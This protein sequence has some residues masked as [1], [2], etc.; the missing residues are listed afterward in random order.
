MYSPTPLSFK[1]LQTGFYFR[2]TSCARRSSVLCLHHTGRGGACPSRFLC[3]CNSTQRP[4][5]LCSL[6]FYF[7]KFLSFREDNIFPYIKGIFSIVGEDIILPF[8]CKCYFSQENDGR[9]VKKREEQA[10]PLPCKR[11][12][13]AL[14]YY[15]AKFYSFRREQAP[16]LQYKLLF[17]ALE[18][19]FRMTRTK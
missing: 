16:A 19:Y 6:K 7:A 10:P 11:L 14:E 9:I 8:L 3:K 12:F 1:K 18:F 2:L 4:C 5:A 17:C 15:F 13:R